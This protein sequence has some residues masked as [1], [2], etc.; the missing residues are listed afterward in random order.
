MQAVILPYFSGQKGDAVRHVLFVFC[1]SVMVALGCSEE[2]SNSAPM[3]DAMPPPSIMDAG[4][5]TPDSGGSDAGEVEPDA[6]EVP[7]S[8]SSDNVLDF[9]AE[10]E[11]AEGQLSVSS[12]HGPRQDAVGSCGGDGNE[13]VFRFAAPSAGLWTFTVSSETTNLDTVMYART[14][15]TNTESELACN[16]DR[17]PNQALVSE[18]RLTLEADQAV[19]VFVDMF[20]GE[21][22]EFTLTARQVPA[23]GFGEACDSAVRLAGCPSDGFC[24]VPADSETGM[25]ICVPNEAPQVGEVS[26]FRAGDWLGI[27]V[28]GTDSG[29]D[30]T[31]G[32]LQLYQGEQRIVLNEENGADTLIMTPILSLF[33]EE[34]FQ[35]LYRASGFSQWSQANAVQVALEDSQ[36]NR[37]DFARAAI[38]EAPVAMEQCDQYRIVDSCPEGLACLDPDGDEQFS[39]VE[40]A[41]PTIT[42]AKGYYDAESLLI[43]FEVSGSDPDNDVS[44]LFL[45]LLDA[46]G[47]RVASGNIAFLLVHC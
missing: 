24:R 45:E 28:T 35:L 5:T 22:N 2:S 39:C 6:G 37:T 4:M 43:G 21:G 19:F 33:G 44:A 31:R 16:D 13:R 20:S 27:Q 8:C 11:E 1:V 3:V 17:I 10:A 23:V 46:E 7:G 34:N 38:V 47:M 41:P 25:G 40:I 9:N 26:V 15:C 14:E 12:R 36:G 42:R 30:V 32:L 18:I 29:G